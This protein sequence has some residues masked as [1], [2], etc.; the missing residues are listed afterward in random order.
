M[1]EDLKNGALSTI[2]QKLERRP[3]SVVVIT[4]ALHAKG[5][6]FEP[7]V[8]Q[9]FVFLLVFSIDILDTNSLFADNNVFAPSIIRWWRVYRLVNS[10]GLTVTLFF[11]INNVFVIVVLPE[12]ETTPLGYFTIGSNHKRIEE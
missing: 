9:F 12:S 3:T 8:D 10:V 4:F 1:V 11:K 2:L 7:H 5:R 6:E